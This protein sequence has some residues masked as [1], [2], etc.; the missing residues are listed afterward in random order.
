MNIKLLDKDSVSCLKIF[1]KNFQ[2]AKFGSINAASTAS[3]AQ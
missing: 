1:I 3:I 2:F